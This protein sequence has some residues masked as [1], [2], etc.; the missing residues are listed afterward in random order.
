MTMFDTPQVPGG[1]GLRHLTFRQLLASKS[2][3]R[4]A[5]R[6]GKKKKEAHAMYWRIEAELEGR[7]KLKW[8]NIKADMPDVA[9]LDEVA[10]EG[11]TYLRA[12]GRL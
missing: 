10:N 5:M 4:R 12:P 11:D 9:A 7:R 3:A 1:D 8:K 6:K 2:L